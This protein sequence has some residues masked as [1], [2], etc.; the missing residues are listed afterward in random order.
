MWIEEG[1]QGITLEYCGTCR[2]PLFQHGGNV[3]M[4]VPGDAP[5]ALPFYVQCRN[6]SCGRKYKV[7]G[8]L[9]SDA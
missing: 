1:G 5:S 8:I 7:H 3:V 4:K 9:A 6:K 2:A